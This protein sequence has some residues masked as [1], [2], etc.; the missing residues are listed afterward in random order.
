[1]DK[2]KQELAS[3]ERR[4]FLKESVVLFPVLKPGLKVM[5][6]ALKLTTLLSGILAE[7]VIALLA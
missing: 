6:L 7:A 3:A 4:N 1:M 5:V 2:T